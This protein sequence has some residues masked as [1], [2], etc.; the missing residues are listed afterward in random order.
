MADHLRSVADST[1]DIFLIASTKFAAQLIGTGAIF[2]GSD[3]SVA[4]KLPGSDRENG[5]YQPLE[6][7]PKI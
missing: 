7:H 4:R 1:L 2:D 3:A 6:N 5:A